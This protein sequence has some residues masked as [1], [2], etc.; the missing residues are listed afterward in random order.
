[1]LALALPTMPEAEEA[2]AFVSDSWASVS[3]LAIQRTWA[4]IAG[5]PAVALA[6]DT[7][8]PVLLVI[9]QDETASAEMFMVNRAADRFLQGLYIRD[10]TFLPAP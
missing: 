9:V 4:D 1:V 7:G 8:V 2:A 3:S 5:A 10:L 6:I